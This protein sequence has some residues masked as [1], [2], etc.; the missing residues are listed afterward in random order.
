MSIPNSTHIFQNPEVIHFRSKLYLCIPHSILEKYFSICVYLRKNYFHLSLERELKN[1]WK[2]PL[3]NNIDICF[4]NTATLFQPNNGMCIVM[5]G[6]VFG[7][8]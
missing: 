6:N 5:Q 7:S 3:Q 4:D 1:K 8:L 2:I